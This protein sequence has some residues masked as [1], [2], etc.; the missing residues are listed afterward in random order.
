MHGG[1]LPRN[2]VKPRPHSGGNLSDS[3]GAK[4]SGGYWTL[5]DETSY[6]KSSQPVLPLALLYLL[7][8]YFP[9]MLRDIPY[10]D[11]AILLQDSPMTWASQPALT[12]QSTTM[13]KGRT[14]SHTLAKSPKDLD[15]GAASSSKIPKQ[16]L[17]KEIYRKIGAANRF[18]KSLNQLKHEGITQ[19][20]KV[21]DE[22]KVPAHRLFATESCSIY[23]LR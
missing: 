18:Q 15:G 9:L 3:I 22:N 8:R 21:D 13:H 20:N 17:P 7:Y 11:I 14:E 23:I 16:L 2:G 19:N 5:G 4:I 10:R 1:S 6:Y 12:V